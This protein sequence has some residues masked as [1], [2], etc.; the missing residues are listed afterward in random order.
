[1]TDRRSA[2]R[3]HRAPRT[4][5][6]CARARP[7]WRRREAVSATLRS[8]P[9]STGSRSAT[10]APSARS[11]CREV[12]GSVWRTSSWPLDGE[13]GHVGEGPE[14]VAGAEPDAHDTDRDRRAAPPGLGMD[15][16]ADLEVEPLEQAGTEDDLGVGGGLSP[17]QQREAE[18]P[19]ERPE[20]VGRHRD[21]VELDLGGLRDGGA[22]D[23]DA[24]P[25]P[26]RSARRSA[27]RRRGRDVRTGWDPRDGRATRRTP[28]HRRS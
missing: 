7:G 8:K 23:G 4:P 27:P 13:G 20:P 3:A 16:V 2:P 9:A 6:G 1:M 15:D 5:R 28:G 25:S 17:V 14:E 12:K 11:T 24:G 19:L 26:R 21:T 22:V 10:V 18:L